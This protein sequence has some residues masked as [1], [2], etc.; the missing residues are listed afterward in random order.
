MVMLVVLEVALL[1]VRGGSR[2]SGDGDLSLLDNHLDDLVAAS[3]GGGCDSVRVAAGF[4]AWSRS[5]R[6]VSSSPLCV[7]VRTVGSSRLHGDNNTT[8]SGGRAG[9]VGRGVGKGWV[10]ESRWRRSLLEGGS[11]DIAG[12]RDWIGGSWLWTVLD[13]DTDWKTIPRTSAIIVLDFTWHGERALRCVCISLEGEDRAI[14]DLSACAGAGLDGIAKELGRVPAHDEIAVVRSA[15]WVTGGD[16]ELAWL[17]GEVVGGVD[18]LEKEEWVVVI[19]AFGAVTLLDQ[20]RVLHVRAVV[21]RVELSVAAAWEGHLHTKTVQAV[22]IHVVLVR[23]LVAVKRSLW[24]LGVVQ[25][26]ET[27]GTLLE[28]ELVG[29][30]GR[31]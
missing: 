28:E 23:E 24:G 16:E 13:R 17:A 27:K 1:L 12:A 10:M 2:L 31:P 22:R 25:A 6:W 9:R 29:G 14:L 30:I 20:A 4:V 5:H 19:V 26:V 21:I 11:W 8:L 3:D 15:D 7:L 18:G